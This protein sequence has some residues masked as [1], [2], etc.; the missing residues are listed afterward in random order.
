MGVSCLSGYILYFG[1]VDM[2]DRNF[3]F[4]KYDAFWVVWLMVT[5][6]IV[7]SPSWF[8]LPIIMVSCS[9]FILALVKG[10][11]IDSVVG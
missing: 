11:L 4:N 9:S 6:M 5:P 2:T 8:I 3:H 10:E 7:I 1:G